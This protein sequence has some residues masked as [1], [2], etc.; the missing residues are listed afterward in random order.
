MTDITFVQ[1]GEPLSE[2]YLAINHY[3]S[4]GDHLGEGVAADAGP[5]RFRVL[6]AV[7]RALPQ[8]VADWECFRS[9]FAELQREFGLRLQREGASMGM[10]MWAFEVR[11]DQVGP[12]AGA[13]RARPGRLGWGSLKPLIDRHVGR[14]A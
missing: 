8:D 10:E 5:G 7:N 11:E 12:L 14:R 3:V 6:L 4:T 9:R 1:Q 2:L 13:L